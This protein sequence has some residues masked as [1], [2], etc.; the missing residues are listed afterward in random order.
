MLLVERFISMEGAKVALEKPPE[1]RMLQRLS[2][3]DH[4]SVGPKS[5]GGSL[6]ISGY[7]IFSTVRL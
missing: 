6:E 7:A 3:N 2:V 4:R 1:L 5:S